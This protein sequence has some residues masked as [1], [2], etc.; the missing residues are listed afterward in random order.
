MNNQTRQLRNN[1][2][3]CENAIEELIEVI[4]TDP[5]GTRAHVVTEAEPRSSSKVT[6]QISTFRKVEID[7]SEHLVG[8]SFG[9]TV[10]CIDSGLCRSEPVY[11][12]FFIPAEFRE[13]AWIRYLFPSITS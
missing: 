9:H 1:E 7:A 11:A 6:F 3:S 4:Q 8:I 13:R 12:P 5:T 10:T 2:N